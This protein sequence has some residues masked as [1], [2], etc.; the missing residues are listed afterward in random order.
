MPFEWPRLVLSI[1]VL[2]I[3]ALAVAACGLS[4]GPGAIW[5]EPGKFTYYHY[6]DLARRWKQLIARENELRNLMERANESTAGAVIGSIAYRGD[7]EAA[8]TKE[9][10]VQRTAGE[11]K[12]GLT[13][14]YQSDHTIR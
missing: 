11:K 13:P 3:A 12:C 4:D 10:M 1:I 5:V 6:D 2:N 9:K 8:L 14:D 7:Y